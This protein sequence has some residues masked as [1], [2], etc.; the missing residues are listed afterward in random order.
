MGRKAGSSL[1]PGKGSCVRSIEPVVV[2]RLYRHLYCDCGL[3]T[4]AFRR[5]VAAPGSLGQRRQS[6]QSGRGS[7]GTS[8]GDTRRLVVRRRA[9]GG[10]GGGGAQVQNTKLTATLATQCLD[11]LVSLGGG[12]QASPHCPPSG[13]QANRSVAAPLPPW[14]K[15]AWEAGRRSVRAPSQL[16]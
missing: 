15:S 14:P 9:R 12:R 13:R 11:P 3:R 6:G 16:G 7:P 2:Y 4:V 1:E 8:L 5:S 10:R